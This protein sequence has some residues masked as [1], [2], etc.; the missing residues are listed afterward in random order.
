MLQKPYDNRVDLVCIDSYNDGI[1]TGRVYHPQLGTCDHF[2]GLTQ[3]LVQMEE[4]LKSQSY[5]PA[6]HDLDVHSGALTT[7]AIRILFQQNAS[8]QG[9]LTWLKEN[10]EWRFR[11]TLELILL[12]DS[13]LTGKEYA[14]G[15]NI[16]HDFQSTERVK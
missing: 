13:I 11:S 1:P 6:P 12:M 8:W 3:F 9:S 16:S 15:N 7:F 5:H 10:K 14:A 2:R 4:S